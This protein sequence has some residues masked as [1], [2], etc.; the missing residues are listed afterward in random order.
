MVATPDLNIIMRVL[1][2]KMY[3]TGGVDEAGEL[4]AKRVI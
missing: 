2:M 1:I 3:L 4:D